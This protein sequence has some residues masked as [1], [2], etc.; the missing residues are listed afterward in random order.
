MRTL[1]QY[2]CMCTYIY[3]YT[4]IYTEIYVCIY[5][6]IEI[7]KGHEICEELINSGKL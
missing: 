5:I 1:S 3:M 4:Y 6:Y 2:V 7:L